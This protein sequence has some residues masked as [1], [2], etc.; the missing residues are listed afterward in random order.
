MRHSIVAAPYTITAWIN[1]RSLWISVMSGSDPG[2][3]PG[4]VSSDGVFPKGMAEG[5]I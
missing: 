1:M 2:I 3:V 5:I 4:L